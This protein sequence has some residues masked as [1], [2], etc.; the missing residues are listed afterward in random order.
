M[1]ALAILRTAVATDELIAALAPRLGRS[2]AEI[3]QRVRLAGE[4]PIVLGGV[5]DRDQATASAAM[6][7]AHG[8]EISVLPALHPIADL[9]TVRE[10][11]LAEGHLG[12]TG[13]DGRTL[14]IADADIRAFVLAWRFLAP[15][16]VREPP[17][18]TRWLRPVPTPIHRERPPPSNPG[19]EGMAYVFTTNA[20]VLLREYGL[21]YRC[22]GRDLQ[23]S[24]AANFMR[25]L[26]RL[27]ERAPQAACDE[28]LRRQ[29]VQHHVL[30]PLTTVDADLELAAA[31]VAACVRR[32]TPGPYRGLS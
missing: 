2:A 17:Q 24:R 21:A 7:R 1:Q 32:P 29:G 28:R 18:P 25:L 22:L 12:V 15:T 4:D 16:P 27:R 30:G 19:H 11:E 9:V 31:L 23:P 26:Q 3:G 8:F 6:L 10:F 13:R 20:T 14:R 5:P